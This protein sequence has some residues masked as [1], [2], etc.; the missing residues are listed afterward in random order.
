[1]A[2][3]DVETLAVP[4]GDGGGDT[5][6]AEVPEARSAPGEVP[7]PEVPE[8]GAVDAGGHG[9]GGD[10]L[11]A[12]A[13][14]AAGLD[15]SALDETEPRVTLERIATGEVLEPSLPSVLGRGP[16]ATCRIEGNDAISRTHARLFV[17]DDGAYVLRDLGS[18]N[19]TYVD[20]VRLEAGD[21]AELRDGAVVTLADERL[22]FRV[23]EVRLS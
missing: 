22:V 4:G 14:D 9:V 7:A 17:G 18:V 11:P 6:V 5:P 3:G 20:G 12:D 16:Q 8:V 10:E 13:F 2:E 19:H 23:G 1:M 15:L 21:E